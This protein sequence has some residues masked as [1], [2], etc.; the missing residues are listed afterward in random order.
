M[1]INTSAFRGPSFGYYPPMPSAPVA[2]DITINVN[3]AAQAAQQYGGFTPYGA[4]GGGC[5]C[6]TSPAQLIDE[7]EALVQQLSSQIHG[8][9][10]GDGNGNSCGEDATS[11]GEPADIQLPPGSPL[12][13][14]FGDQPM[15]GLGGSDSCMPGSSPYGSSGGSPYVQGLT[16]GAY[17]RGYQQGAA[18]AQGEQSAYLQGLAD[19]AYDRGYMQGA[20]EAQAQDC[21][22]P[23][24]FDQDHHH[25]R[26]HGGQCGQGGQGDGCGGSNGRTRGS[27][28]SRSRSC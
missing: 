10:D 19:G 26:S 8:N 16:Q 21:Q 28:S 18:A 11:G 12:A 17:C 3:N 13:G 2:T 14:Q 20:A 15:P 9:G 25:H 23:Q 6:G 7:I 5:G 27:S 1:E 4:S 24:C 22:P